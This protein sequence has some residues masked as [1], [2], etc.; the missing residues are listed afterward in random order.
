M[1]IIENYKRIQEIIFRTAESCS[2]N[3]DEIKIIA[4]TKNFS[5]E[6]MQ[7]AID[8]GI[9]ILGEN[10]VQEAKSKIPDLKGEYSLHMIGHLQSNKAKDAVSLFNLI[11]SIDKEETAQ[12]VNREAGRIN[13]IQKILVQVNASG[14]DTKSGIEPANC[15]DIIKKITD[16]KSVEILGLMT[17]APFT[18]DDNIIRKTFRKTRE[19]LIDVNNRLNINLREL[20]MGMS[21]DYKIAIEEGATMVRIGTAIFGERTY[22]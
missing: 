6:I 7:D 3:P 21:S 15:L 2:R 13:K 1:T 11:H 8:S 19:L 5:A 18:D 17:M 9:S 10:R 14:E 22:T 12:K 16:M 20:S 4:V